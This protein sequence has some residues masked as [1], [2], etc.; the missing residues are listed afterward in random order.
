LTT[1][2]LLSGSAD[3]AALGDVFWL[4]AVL[5]VVFLAFA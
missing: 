5:P 1:I 4:V 2:G 3:E